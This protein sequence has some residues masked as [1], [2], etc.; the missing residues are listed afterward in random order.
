MP[1]CGWVVGTEDAKE[2]ESTCFCSSGCRHIAILGDA[3]SHAVLRQHQCLMQGAAAN[4]I[5]QVGFHPRTFPSTLTA[6]R[7][8][9]CHEITKCNLKV[10]YSMHKHWSTARVPVIDMQ[11]PYTG[12]QPAWAHERIVSMR[13]VPTLPLLLI[14]CLRSGPNTFNSL[15]NCTMASARSSSLKS[16]LTAAGIC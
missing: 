6:K 5:T 8:G 11:L 1:T 16:A 9:I 3:T 2:G 15:S 13:H 4:G 10:N 14:R 12:F 7:I